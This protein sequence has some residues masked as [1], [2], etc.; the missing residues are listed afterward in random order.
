MLHLDSCG[1]ETGSLAVQK[2]NDQLF[3]RDTA[4]GNTVPKGLDVRGESRKLREELRNVRRS[5]VIITEMEIGR[6]RS[7]AEVEGGEGARN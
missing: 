5:P 6:L 1:R 2:D 3:V 7:V 4:E